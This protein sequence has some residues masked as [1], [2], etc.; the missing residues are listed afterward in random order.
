VEL[1]E[2]VVAWHEAVNRADLDRVVA[3]STEDVVVGGP[4]GGG[5]GHDVLREWVTRAG[6]HLEPGTVHGDG[7]VVVVEQTAWWQG[8]G[9]DGAAEPAELASVFE[10]RDGRVA[11]VVRYPSLADA[12]AAVEDV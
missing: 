4:R 12:R 9:A 10:V 2:L 8:V 1:T 7:P 5:S 11:R 3:L 6:I